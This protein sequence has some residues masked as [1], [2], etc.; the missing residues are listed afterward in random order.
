MQ[1]APQDATAP[2]FLGVVRAQQGRNREALAL[3]DTALK[4]K[5]MRRNPVQLW[6]CAA[7]P[8]AGLSEALAAL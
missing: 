8:K 7:A 5:P 2:H 1:A 3:M 6:Q 4:L